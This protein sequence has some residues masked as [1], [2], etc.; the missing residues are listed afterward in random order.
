MRWFDCAPSTKRRR[1]SMHLFRRSSF[2]LMLLVS[3]ASCAGQGAAS[4]PTVPAATLPSATAPA[5][6]IPASTDGSPKRPFPQHT[7]YA[8]GTIKPNQHTQDELDAAVQK[9]Y[10]AWKQA[11]LK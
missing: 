2:I 11:Y 9:A 3:L 5:T 4:A 8:P 1:G 6:T 10:R 7:A